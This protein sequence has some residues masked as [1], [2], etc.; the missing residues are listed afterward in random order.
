MSARQKAK[1]QELKVLGIC[2]ECRVAKARSK[3]LTCE[4][5]AR[6]IE[7]KRFIRY[8]ALRLDAIEHYG[9]KCACCGEDNPAFLQF[10]HKYGGGGEH[11][12][13]D[14]LA[15]S[16][17]GLWTKKHGYPDWIRLLCANCNYARQIN[18]RCPHDIAG[19]MDDA[20]DVAA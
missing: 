10:D 8:R 14:V 19:L 9:G 4:S 11:R 13:F 2:R 7:S 5:C 12:R 3:R 1:L 18:G 20:N 15:A 17:M 16:N 6:Q